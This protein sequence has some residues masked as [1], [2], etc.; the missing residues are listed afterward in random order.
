MNKV[1]RTLING[2]VTQGD[3]EI[4]PVLLVELTVRECLKV[5]EMKETRPTTNRHWES[6][7]REVSFIIKDHFGVEE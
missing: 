4:D 3:N 2:S 6:I 7:G 5:L 1:I